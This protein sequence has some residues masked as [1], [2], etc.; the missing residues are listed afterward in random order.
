MNTIIP[1]IIP[2]SF[3]HIGHA[4]GS[5]RNSAPEVQVDIVDG[6]LAPFVS[7]PYR[8]SGSVM[9]LREHTKTYLI[10]VDLMIQSPEKILSQYVEAGVGKVVIHLESVTDLDAIY[11]HHEAHDYALGLSVGNDTSLEV[12][13]KELPHA[14]YVQLMG[15]R[16]IGSQG[17]PFDTEVLTRIA[18]IRALYPDMVISIDGSVNEA[19]LPLLRDAGANRFVSGSA[20]FAAE[21]PALAYTTLTTL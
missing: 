2:Q 10:E 1:A 11:V 18:R 15:I 7:W 19:T 14:D 4:I 13:E 5:L 3:E 21:D 16:N 20:I 9:L 6:V 12:L 17:Q 8:G